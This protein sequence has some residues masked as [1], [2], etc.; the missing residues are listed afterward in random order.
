MEQRSRYYQ[1]ETHEDGKKALLEWFHHIQNT[2]GEARGGRAD[3]AN[4][5]RAQSPEDIIYLDAF[6]RFMRIP[7]IPA[8][9]KEA[10]NWLVLAMVAGALAHG[11]T[12][13]EKRKGDEKIDSFARQLG[14]PL[15]KGGKAPLSELRFTQLQK[16]RD[17]DEFYLR[18]IRAIRL[19]KRNVNVISLADSILHWHREH[20]YGVDRIPTKRL[21]VNWARDY[22]EVAPGDIN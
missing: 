1:F 4:L 5:R 15:E 11:Q 7:E 2:D 8:E 9:L 17:C 13:L 16:S 14:R 10:D 6:H 18:L 19:L 21:A 3:R 20:C 22:F 12:I